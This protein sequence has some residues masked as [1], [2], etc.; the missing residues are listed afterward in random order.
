MRLVPCPNCGPREQ[1]EFVCLGETTPR[2][3]YLRDNAKGPVTELWWHKHGCR[4]WLKLARNT[5]TNEF[6]A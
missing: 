5:A 6:G 3:I 2:E 1:A 4:H